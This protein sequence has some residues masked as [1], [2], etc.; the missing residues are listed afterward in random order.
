[1]KKL[2]LYFTNRIESWKIKKDRKFLFF[3][4]KPKD[5]EFF[6]TNSIRLDE[7]LSES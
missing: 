5:E 2:I 4:S 3:S 1:M 7:L 6:E